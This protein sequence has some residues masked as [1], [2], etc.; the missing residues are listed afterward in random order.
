M[1]RFILN[2]KSEF[3]CVLKI[4]DSTGTKEY[5]LSTLNC[6]YGNPNYVDVQVYGEHIEVSLTPQNTDFTS[7]LN[8]IEADGL[9]GK[10]TAKL[11]GNV[12]TKEENYFM[13]TECRY[14]LS[15]VEDGSIVE[16]D[17][18]M[19]P[20]GQLPVSSVLDALLIRYWFF[21]VSCRTKLFDM[22]DAKVLNK[23]EVLKHYKKLAMSQLGSMSIVWEYPLK[24]KYA[25]HYLNDDVA[26]EKL[27]EFNKMNED[28]RKRIIDK[29]RMF[30]DFES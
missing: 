30:T 2:K 21:E 10:I 29:N 1:V 27:T 12:L 23:S 7:A 5:L 16:I 20:C 18:Q 25:K 4:T 17:H 15:G 28:Q 14:N 22:I 9:A 13:L 19:Y 11:L 26:T 6:A 3:D 24:M 8:E